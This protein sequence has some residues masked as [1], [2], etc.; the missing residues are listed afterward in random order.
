MEK[1]PRKAS[2]II[3]AMENKID[4]LLGLVRSL[5]LNIKILSNKLNQLSEKQE[6]SPP[7]ITME[8]VHVATPHVPFQSTFQPDPERAILIDPENNALMEA[9]PKGFR[10]T[11]RPETFSGDNAYLP[12][13]KESKAEVIVPNKETPPQPKEATHPA[14]Q[15]PPQVIPTMQRV[16]NRNG[17]SIF[18]ADVEITNLETREVKR[19]R[20]NGTGKWTA[21]L[22]AGLYRV[23]VKKQEAASNEML[24]VVQD[25]KIDGKTSP[26][27]LNILIIK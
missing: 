12:K 6:A 3:L 2:E 11:S 26:L 19:T 8:A 18:L 1:E 16:V 17:K 9:N 23:A 22:Q 10:R 13:V 5:D 14:F 24:E 20:T 25:I 15:E 27:E 4:I 21:P 7:K